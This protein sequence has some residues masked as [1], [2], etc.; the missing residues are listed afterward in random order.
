MD[1]IFNWLETKRSFTNAEN[2][3]I[4]ILVLSHLLR[5]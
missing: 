5:T 2:L 4:W 3:V 1:N